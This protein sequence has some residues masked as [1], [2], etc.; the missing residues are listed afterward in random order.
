[1]I[2]LTLWEKGSWTARFPCPTCSNRSSRVTEALSIHVSAGGSLVLVLLL[3]LGGCKRKKCTFF[4][5]WIPK[6]IGLT[7]WEKS[8]WPAR[9]PCP[10]YSNRSMRSTEALSI[11]VSAGGRGPRFWTVVEPWSMREKKCTFFKPEFPKWFAWFCE[12]K[13][14]EPSDFLA[15]PAR[16]IRRR[17]IYDSARGASLRSSFKMGIIDFGCRITIWS[18]KSSLSLCQPLYL[19][20]D[21]V[22]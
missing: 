22:K 5:A 9:F 2:G 12:K 10:T 7:L 8:S 18:G 16:S 13:V 14:P 19:L 6:M 3:S 21:F 11:H 15:P 17:F 20:L 1:M 4:Q